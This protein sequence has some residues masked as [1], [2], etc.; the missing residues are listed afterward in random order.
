MTEARPTP[1]NAENHIVAVFDHADQVTKALDALHGA[2]IGDESISVLGRDEAQAGRGGP[3][4]N[5]A[6]RSDGVAGHGAE[7]AGAPTPHAESGTPEDF[8]EASSTAGR[9]VAKGAAVGGAAGGLVGLLGGAL[10]VAL[11]GVGTAVGIGMLVGAASG[12][13]AGA[14][15]GAMWSGFER[16]WDMGYRDMVADGG[17]LVAVHATDAGMADR[18]KTVL[19]DLGPRRIDHLDRHGE[20]VREV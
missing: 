19:A 9:G 15:A 13:T 10:A 4:A 14:T 3:G 2:G 11:P 16:M 7:G 1:E 8:Y 6:A 18:A 5:G 20:I 17:V 12:A